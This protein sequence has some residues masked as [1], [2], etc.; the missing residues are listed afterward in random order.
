MCACTYTPISNT[1]ACP[2]ASNIEACPNADEDYPS[3]CAVIDSV[4]IAGDAEGKH[5]DKGYYK[6]GYTCDP[7]HFISFLPIIIGVPLFY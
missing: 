2:N 5:N 4:R 3:A 6:K 1:D 7:V